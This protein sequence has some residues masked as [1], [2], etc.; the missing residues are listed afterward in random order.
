MVLFQNSIFTST[1]GFQLEFP[2][3]GLLTLNLVTESL[4]CEQLTSVQTH[5]YKVL[6]PCQGSK[7]QQDEKETTKRGRHS[8]SPGPDPRCVVLVTDGFI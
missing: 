3:Y 7:N 1:T 2:S 8:H 6:L 4:V 5:S